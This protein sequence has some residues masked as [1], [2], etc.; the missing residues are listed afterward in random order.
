MA[1]MNQREDIDEVL[2]SGELSEAEEQKLRLAMSLRDYAASDLG[3]SV[4]DSYAQ[5]VVLDSSYVSWNVF[6]AKPLEM[7]PQQWCFPVAG[8]VSY[9]GYF[10]KEDAEAFAAKLRKKGL[11]TYVSGVG[12]Y[13]TL[14]WFDDPILSSFLSLE[15]YR[16]AALL[17]HELAHRQFYLKGDT[18]FNES[19]ATA[20]EQLALE[21]WLADTGRSQQYRH[22]EMRQ[23]NQAI[24]IRWVES[25]RERLRELYDE[26]ISDEEKL[27]ARQVYWD[28]MRDSFTE[29]VVQHPGLEAYGHWVE[30]ELNNAR[31][32]SLASYN[33]WVDAFRQ[34]FELS[35][36]QWPEFYQQ[37]E[38]L[39]KLDNNERID[40]LQALKAAY[41][42]ISCRTDPEMRNNEP[43]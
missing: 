4:E 22:Y 27:Q 26:P 29:L 35:Q 38:P 41:Q 40:E 37:L 39:A 43:R 42:G 11:D 31:L 24:F 20:V 5:L 9:R 18:A 10:N 7:T 30:A 25:H 12:A 3:M 32:L 8:C 17:F 28:T 34:L 1:L 21:Q 19:Y 6:A 23:R 16:L 14:G 33:D 15:D 13:S 36:C 2:A